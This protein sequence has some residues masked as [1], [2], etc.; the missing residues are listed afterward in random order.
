MQRAKRILSS[1][2]QKLA[3]HRL[4]WAAAPFSAAEKDESLDVSRGAARCGL[5]W[6]KTERGMRMQRPGRRSRRLGV[7]SHGPDGSLEG[8]VICN[9]MTR[10]ASTWSFNV[11]MELFRRV[12]GTQT[13]YGGYDENIARFLSQAPR[14][15]NRLVVKCHSLD[16]LGRVLARTG[17]AKVIYTRRDAADAVA[18]A[19]TMWDQDFEYALASVEASLELYAFHRKLGTALILDY[20]DIVNSPRQSVERIAAHLGLGLEPHMIAEVAEATSF[21]RM[22]EK[23][24]QLTD[25]R[26]QHRVVQVDEVRYDRESLLHPGHIQNGGSGYGRQLLSADR[27]AKIDCILARSGS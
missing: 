22:R 23:A 9:G 6:P 17:R 1:I 12:G 24:Q 5:S 3:E 26:S 11:A 7:P 19:M 10:S 14:S 8:I 15:A 21:E 20:E 16:P 13:P 27:L 2:A 18:S 25:P 4:Q